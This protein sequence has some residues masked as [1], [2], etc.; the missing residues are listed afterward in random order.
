[1][2]GQTDGPMDEWP[3]DRKM[4]KVKSVHPIFYFTEVGV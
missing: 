1:M 4:D 3:M 2:G